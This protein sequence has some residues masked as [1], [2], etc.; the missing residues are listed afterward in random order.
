MTVSPSQIPLNLTSHNNQ[1]FFS[2]HYLNDILRRS[3]DWR[4]AIPPAQEFLAW[5]RHLYAQEKAQLPH[6]KESQLEDNWFK[7][8]FDRLGHVWEGQAAVPGLQKSAKKP[9]F[10]FF[11]RLSPAGVTLILGDQL[12]GTISIFPLDHHQIWRC[13]FSFGKIAWHAKPN[14]GKTRGF[15]LCGIAVKM[16]L[17]RR[18]FSRHFHSCNNM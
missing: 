7:P 12:S 17:P 13:A 5:L 1:S 8:I 2:D 18:Q 11:C 14:W 10:V 4:R 6:Y 3:D 9:D 16:S 15:T